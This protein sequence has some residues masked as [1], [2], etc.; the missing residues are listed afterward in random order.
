MSKFLALTAA[1]SLIATA[2]ALA[3]ITSIDSS[4]AAPKQ[5][6]GNPNRVICEVQDTIGT[7]LGRRKVCLT[8][9][10]WADKRTEHRA[11]IEDIQLKAQDFTCPQKGCN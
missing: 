7:R 1:L 3:Q 9:Q 11:M 5:V 6:A 4:N 10:Q 2:P 8:A